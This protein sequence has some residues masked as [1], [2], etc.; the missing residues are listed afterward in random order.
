LAASASVR[1]AAFGSVDGSVGVGSVGV[2]VGVGAWR[3]IRSPPQ[4]DLPRISPIV[5]PTT[6]TAW[7]SGVAS[8]SISIPDDLPRTS[9]EPTSSPSTASD[10]TTRTSISKRFGFCRRPPPPR[11]AFWIVRSTISS[12]SPGSPGPAKL[13]F[14]NAQRCCTWLAIICCSAPTW[15]W[16]RPAEP[17]RT[18][19][20]R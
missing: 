6:S 2:G 19:S 13:T 17:T 11:D 3:A 8:P 16:P 7:S 10:R 18:S 14:A 1:L 4:P 20:E 12:P 15:S 9:A 5:L